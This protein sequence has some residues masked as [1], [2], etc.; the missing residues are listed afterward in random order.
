MNR[1][2]F[3]TAGTMALAGGAIGAAKGSSGA[4]PGAGKKGTAP[5]AATAFPVYDLHVHTSKDQTIQQILARAKAGGFEGVGVMKN[6]APF[7]IRN[8]GD[9]S[10]FLAETVP[11]HVWR[12]LQPMELGWSKNLSKGLVDQVDYVLLDPQTIRKGN[13]YGDTLEVWEHECYIPDEDEF[14]EVNM[15]HYQEILASQE[16]LDIFG[17]PLYLPPCIARDYYRLW[18]NERMRQVIAWVKGRGVALE[19]NDLAQTPHAE[20]ILMAKQ[21]GIKFTFGSDTRNERTGRLDY[22]K[23]IARL[24][25]LTRA[26]F[27]IPPRKA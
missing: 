6:V 14:M 13:R 3:I 26:D 11:F 15:K 10:A 17:W 22:C 19:I 9:L 18:T 20:F 12:G 25:G 27:F 4:L 24:C 2:G 16:R 23:R 7:G 5:E 8:D 21:A 1:R